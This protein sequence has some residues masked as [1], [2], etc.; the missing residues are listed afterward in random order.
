MFCHCI[1]F[2]DDTTLYFSHQDIKYLEWCITHNLAIL[3]DWFRA[4]KLTLNIDKS[5]F[6]LFRH[7]NLN[8]EMNKLHFDGVV[9]PQYKSTK[10]LGIYI[11]DKLNWQE[12]FNM[13]PTLN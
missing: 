12:H 3:A 9:I 13:S 5:V 4:N 1:L 8:P 11:D 10:F 6:L 2:A 7:G